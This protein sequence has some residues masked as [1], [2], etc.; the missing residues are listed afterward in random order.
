MGLQF[1]VDPSQL[2]ENS[3]HDGDPHL[4]ARRLSFAKAT[5]VAA[6]WNHAVVIGADT[7]GAIEGRLLR[8]PRNE[9]DAVAMLESMSGRRH[10]VVTAFTLIDTD[11]GK[12]IT[13]S[14]ETT[15]WFRDLTAAEIKAYVATGEPMDKA[16]AYAIQG[17]GAALVAGI[18]GDYHNVIGLPVAALGRS[19]RDFGVDVVPDRRA[20]SQEG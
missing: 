16:G 13:Q 20:S 5:E 8:K 2:V 17:L 1:A 6:R 12:T 7:L 9:R 4:L 14:V 3:D 10:T 11:T 15:V 19:F 18:E